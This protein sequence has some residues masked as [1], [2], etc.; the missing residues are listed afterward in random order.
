MQMYYRSLQ[1]KRRHKREG[2][3]RIL[4]NTSAK[5]RQCNEGIFRLGLQFG[6]RGPA[7]TN[8]RD[9]GLCGGKWKGL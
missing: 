8:V 3:E 4:Q 7:G 1:L 9:E 6:E 2:T 5:V